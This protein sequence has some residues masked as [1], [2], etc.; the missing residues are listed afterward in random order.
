MTNAGNIGIGTRTPTAKIHVVGNANITGNLTVGTIASGTAADS[1][2]TISAAG[3]VN[4]R[5]QLPFTN[6]Y[7]PNSTLGGVR[8]NTISTSAVTTLDVRTADTTASITVGSTANTSGALFFGNANH[9]VRRSFPSTSANNNNVGLYTT[10]ANLYLSAKGP[11]VDSQ[12]VLTTNG[13]VGMGTNNPLEALEV[14][15]SI[16]LSS[17]TIPMSIY[18]ENNGTTAPILNLGINFRETNKN[19]AYRGGAVRVDTRGVSNAMFQFLSRNVGSTTDNIVAAID[20]SGDLQLGLVYA[21]PTSTATPVHIDMGN[22][23]SPT[24]GQNMKIGVLGSTYG[25]GVSNLQL[26]YMVPATG[27]HVFYVA[28]VEKMRLSAAGNLTVAGTITP[29]DKRLKSHIKPLDYGL[30]TILQLAPKQYE[31]VKTIQIKNG[32]PVVDP[33]NPKPYHTIGFIAQE[34]NKV[35]PEAVH[36][37]TDEANEIWGVDYTKMV[38]VLTRAIQEQQALIETLNNKNELLQHQLTTLS[39]QVKALLQSSKVNK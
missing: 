34:L 28:G 31:Q 38:P 7:N 16:Q 22:T 39:E 18:A 25:F 4:R 37:P 13:K 32:R 19:T 17:A 2:L 8:I 27:N 12:F 15:G 9:G 11:S 24:G 3:L 10:T 23:Y 21:F 26:D 5:P 33:S 1:L 30:Q 14:K 6:V 36:K 29:S 35:V 20:S